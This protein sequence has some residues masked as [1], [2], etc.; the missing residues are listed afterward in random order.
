MFHK[1]SINSTFMFYVMEN[2]FHFYLKHEGT[3]A[4]GSLFH[5]N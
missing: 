1:T 5:V 3:I 2:I 4:A